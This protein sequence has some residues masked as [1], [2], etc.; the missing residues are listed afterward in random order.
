MTLWSVFAHNRRRI[1]LGGAEHK[2]QDKGADRIMPA[3]NP[4]PIQGK[5]FDVC[6]NGTFIMLPCNTYSHT[7]NHFFTVNTYFIIRRT[8]THVFALTSSVGF[9]PS[10]GFPY[11][12]RAAL[13]AHFPHRP[14]LMSE[15]RERGNDGALLSR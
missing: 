15:L 1:L 8:N 12:C 14:R 5:D 6:L 7:S 4:V 13:T 3:L 10:E 2:K 9:V 11:S